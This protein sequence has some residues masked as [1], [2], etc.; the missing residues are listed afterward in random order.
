MLDLIYT[1]YHINLINLFLTATAFGFYFPPCLKKDYKLLSDILGMFT[2][3]ILMHKHCFQTC[4]NARRC[5]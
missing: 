4:A 2:T 1:Y 5:I 3:L